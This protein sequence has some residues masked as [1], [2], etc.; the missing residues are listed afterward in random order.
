MKPDKNNIEE[1]LQR[2]LPSAPRGQME[3]ALDRVLT[4]L[5]TDRGW[6]M[7][8]RVAPAEPAP[9]VS[10]WWKPVMTCAAAAA[11]IAVAI[12]GRIPEGNSGVYA[13]LEAADAS[14]YRIAGDRRIPVQ[15][16]ERIR[17]RE[18]VRSNGGS[19]AMLALAD[20]S[21]IEMRSQSELALERADDGVSIRLGAGSI[22]V[23][24]AQ[25]PKGHLYVQTKDMTVAVV[26]TVFL[27]N[28]EETGSR[29]VVIEGEVRVR[30]GQVETRLRPGE[31][32]SSSSA[33][34]TRPLKEE[35][36]WSRHAD[37]HLAILNSFMKGMAETSGPLRPLANAARPVEA[38]Q[39]SPAAAQPAFEETSIRECDPDN[40]P[41][42]PAGARGGGANSFQMTPGRLHALCMTLATILRHAYGYGPADLD[43][44]NPG[45][46]GRGLNMNIVYGLGV[47]DGR[48]VRGGP[49]WVRN[50]RYTIDAVAADAADAAAMS[51]PMLRA[52]LESRFNLKVHIEAEQIPAFTLT[53]APGGP[54]IKP[55]Q[56]SGIS[57]DGFVSTVVSSDACDAPPAVQP[58]EPFFFRARSFADVRRGE[59]PTCGISVQANGPNQVVVG[60]AAMMAGFARSL[61]GPLG[62]VQV[63]DKTG[64]SD[65]FNFVFEF[66]WDENTPGRRLV[67]PEQAGPADLPRAAT[68]F[69]ALEEQ[70]GLKLEPARAPRDVIVIDQVERPSPN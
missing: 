9:R 65:R 45:G 68:I 1:V 70:L 38:V 66:A 23:N 17:E 24:A 44:L 37:A 3:A 41:R 34:A 52:L 12:W 15:P 64:I 67:V 7:P 8:E 46:R 35:I 63:F 27:V 49:D 30:E 54:K 57:P 11:L 26:G 61:G 13:V 20:G 50:E 47:E 29:V 58:G 53:V 59:K 5:R 10:W 19:G 36:A 39:G 6:T 4:R 31:Q 33:L 69:T 32:V 14:L 48:R 18:T 62:N 40:L 42:A 60:G 25:Q 28:T 16:G 2:S 43:F 56:A 22:I 55:V 51:G 21:R